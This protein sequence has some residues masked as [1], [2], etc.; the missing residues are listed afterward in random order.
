MSL[1]RKQALKTMIGSGVAAAAGLATGLRPGTALAATGAR[2]APVIERDVVVL[3]GGSS[4]T[5][6]AV[7]LRDLGRSVLV[8]ESKNSRRC[9]S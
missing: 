8:V 4:G 3:G 9:T 2:P 6:T 7:R 5:Y 1:T